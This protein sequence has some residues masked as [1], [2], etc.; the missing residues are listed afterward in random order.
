VGTCVASVGK[1]DPLTKSVIMEKPA[2]ANALI[3]LIGRV[4][5]TAA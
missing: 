1:V 3:A 2:R 5:T 4:R